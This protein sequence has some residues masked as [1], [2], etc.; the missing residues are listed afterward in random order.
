MYLTAVELASVLALAGLIAVRFA[1]G[2]RD[3]CFI[4]TGLC[5]AVLVV[6]RSRPLPA[7]VGEWVRDLQWRTKPVGGQGL[8]FYGLRILRAS[9]AAIVTVAANPGGPG[10]GKEGEPQMRVYWSVDRMRNPKTQEVFFNCLAAHL[11]NLNARISDE[12]FD[13]AFK[14]F[15]AAKDMYPTV[16]TNFKFLEQA[17]VYRQAAH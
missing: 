10:D 15:A 6:H 7:T 14:I 2:Y 9:I 3:S 1:V 12:E 11:Y 5:L 4:F 16:E 8:T 17:R 13:H